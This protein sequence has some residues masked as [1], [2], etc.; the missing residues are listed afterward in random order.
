VESELRLDV[1]FAALGLD[2]IA[3]MRLSNQMLRDLG[4]TVHL[5]QILTC[6]NLLALAEAIATEDGDGS[7]P[8]IPTRTVPSQR[9]EGGSTVDARGSGDPE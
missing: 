6:S 1:G 4:R 9:T 7:G 3:A 8:A 5:G 2:S